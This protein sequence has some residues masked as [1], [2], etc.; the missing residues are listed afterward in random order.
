MV[1]VRL[2]QG[3]FQNSS[4][5]FQVFSEEPEAPVT[6]AEFSFLPYTCGF[7]DFPKK[8]D[9]KVIDAKFVL[10]GPCVPIVTSRK[11]LAVER[12]SSSN[13]YI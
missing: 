13:K 1:I 12:G 6:R 9:Q 5:S 4:E 3:C 2:A 7:W 11:R 8:R 10:C